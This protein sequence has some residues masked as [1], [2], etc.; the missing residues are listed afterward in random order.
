MED[1][2][3]SDVEED[4]EETIAAPGKENENP[5]PRKGLK[6]TRS[7]MLKNCDFRTK[8][9]SND[10]SE[11]SMP[12][13]MIES[14]N[15]DGD[16]AP[17]SAGEGAR[18]SAGSYKPPYVESTTGGSSRLGTQGFGEDTAIAG[19]TYADSDC[20]TEDLGASRPGHDEQASSPTIIASTQPAATTTSSSKKKVHWTTDDG[21]PMTAE[22]AH[23]Y[24]SDSGFSSGYRSDVSMKS[25]GSRGRRRNPADISKGSPLEREGAIPVENIGDGVNLAR[26]N[27]EGCTSRP[28]SNSHAYGRDNIFHEAS[29]CPTREAIHQQ[30]EA[31]CLPMAIPS[32]TLSGFPGP[33]L[34]T[35]SESYD[36]A[37][38]KSSI[39]DDQVDGHTD[40]TYWNYGSQSPFQQFPNFSRPHQSPSKPGLGDA[41]NLY[42]NPVSSPGYGTRPDYHAQP[43]AFH[44]STYFSDSTTRRDFSGYEAPGFDVYSSPEDDH[45]AGQRFAPTS[46]SEGGNHD[47]LFQSR[48]TGPSA[49]DFSQFGEACHGSEATGEKFVRAKK[50]AD[51]GASKQNIQTPNKRHSWQLYDNGGVDGGETG[52]AGSGGCQWRD[53]RTT[54]HCSGRT[55]S[56]GNLVTILS[57]EEIKSDDELSD[58][59]DGGRCQPRHPWCYPVVAELL[60]SM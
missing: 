46:S 55:P 39:L 37:A 38:A 1:A 50:F 15:L 40:P 3:L 58:A 16:N 54:M 14:L 20:G 26:E 41:R 35:P 52:G 60:M 45:G 30:H 44:S 57:I 18:L 56:S 5:K 49:F 25:T 33:T 31:G 43:Y 48:P 59:G 21:Q 28:Q 47:Y 4:E 10:S 29:G 13:N 24:N 36:S 12:L 42:G 22:S 6:A 2:E 32:Q 9:T 8:T 11:G 34:P 23:P 7:F 27:N 53:G 17:I 51:A 19:A